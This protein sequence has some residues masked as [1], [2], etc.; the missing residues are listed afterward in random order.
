LNPSGRENQ[1]AGSWREYRQSA[2]AQC[3][4]R[5][6][7]IPENGMNE[8]ESPEDYDSVKS[9]ASAI[10]RM[11]FRLSMASFCILLNASGSERP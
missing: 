3:R 5:Y 10:C 9:I 6:N 7:I 11:L 2:A 1:R 8:L 4:S